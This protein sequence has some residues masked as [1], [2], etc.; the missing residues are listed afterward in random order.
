[1]CETIRHRGPDG[2]G[3]FEQ[4]DI[5]LGHRRLSV[6]DP[7]GSQQPMFS[8]DRNIAIVF[9]GE[10]YNFAALREELTALGHSFQTRGDTETLIY[11]YAQYGVDMLQKIERDVRVRDLG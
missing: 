1:M 4:G 2:E 9:N 10:I 3:Y 7:A 8:R 5:H 6:I 11:A